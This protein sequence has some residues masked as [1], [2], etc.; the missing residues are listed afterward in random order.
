MVGILVEL[1][2]TC[3]VRVVERRRKEKVPPYKGRVGGGS[4]NIIRVRSTEIS[5]PHLTYDYLSLYVLD[6]FF[7]KFFRT[8]FVFDCTTPLDRFKNG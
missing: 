5:L 1:S 6:R 4:R 8:F 7:R 2:I 3:T